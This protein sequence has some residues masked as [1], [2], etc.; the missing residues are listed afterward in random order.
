MIFS[1]F[2]PDVYLMQGLHLSNQPQLSLFEIMLVLLN[3]SCSECLSLSSPLLLKGD[4]SP[5]ADGEQLDVTGSWY[6]KVFTSL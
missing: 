1:F 3:N 2:A 6:N 5:T 4:C